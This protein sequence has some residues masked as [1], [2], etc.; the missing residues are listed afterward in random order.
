[1][2]HVHKNKDTNIARKTCISMWN[3][4]SSV[5]N[6]CQIL[7]KWYSCLPQRQKC[8]YP[9]FRVFLVCVLPHSGWIRTTKTSDTDTFQAVYRTHNFLFLFSSVKFIE[10]M[11]MVTKIIDGRASSQRLEIVISNLPVKEENK[12][13]FNAN[14]NK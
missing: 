12:E 9:S 6:G 7:R 1:M 8:P 2:V 13:S 5:R 14:W 10:Y 11:I 4:D 3:S